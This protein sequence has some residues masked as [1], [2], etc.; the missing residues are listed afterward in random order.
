MS[1]SPTNKTLVICFSTASL[2]AEIWTNKQ[3]LMSRLSKKNGYKV[4]YVDQGMSTREF[5]KAVRDKDWEYFLK[6]IWKFNDNLKCLSFYFLPLIKGGWLKKLAWKILYYLIKKTEDITK[7]DRVIFWVYEP[8]SWY[9]IKQI[10]SQKRKWTVLYDCVDDFK[11]QPL[12]SNN[13]KRKEELI[14]IEK[15]LVQYADIVTTTSKQLFNDKKTLNNSTHY[16]HNVGDYEH[17]KESDGLLP[18]ELD[19]LIS[20]SEKKIVYAGVIDDYKIDLELIDH[21]S[22]QKQFHFLFL[23]PVR[24]NKKKELFRKIKEKKNVEFF[25]LVEYKILPSILHECDVIWLPYQKNEHTK[26]VFPLKL[27]E[28]FATGKQVAG[29]DLNSYSSFHTYM[30]I[31]RDSEEAILELNKENDTK[32]A[33]ERKNFAKEN[34]WDSRLNKILKILTN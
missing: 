21:V 16:V 33:L 10:N 23:G 31:F 7:Y 20:I 28:A 27:F 29:R 2:K 17:F 34:S 6:P 18:K 32:T 25:G 24:V 22:D 11:S 3:H 19:Y 12:Y 4:I 5:K 8:Q 15:A 30:Q 1:S 26:Y 14:E 9:L 13:K